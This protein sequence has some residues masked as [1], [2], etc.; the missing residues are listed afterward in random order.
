VSGK[1]VIEYLLL[2]DRLI[3]GSAMGL[4]F[5][6]A[7]IYT[8]FGV[9]MPMSAVQMTA[10]SDPQG[11][12]G[13][14]EGQAMYS[15][16]TNG[17]MMPAMWSATYAGL[18]FLM[19][20]I[21]MIAMMLPSVTSTVL[22]YMSLIRR[23]DQAVNAPKLAFFFLIGYLAVWGLFSFLATLAQWFLE[24]RGVVSPMGMAF[25]SN[26]MGAT[27]LIIVGIY[28]FTPWKQSCLK[29]CRS[30]IK[31]L[32]EKHR[33]GQNGALLMGI[34]HGAFCLG[35]CW[36]LMVLLLVGG[37][38]NLYWIAGLMLFVLTEKLIRFGDKISR[39]T[40]MLMAGA[41]IYLL[42]SA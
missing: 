24:L 38:M 9:G 6:I 42:I 28:Q 18:V 41:G 34:E 33:T 7:V 37:I 13:T 32:S 20:W 14:S 29:H 35:C 39:L 1:P 21:M 27:V 25:T 17:L 3:T 36:C 40:G 31:F 5:L 22:L 19:W 4:I 8:I 11:M 15:M 16:Q 30:P 23:G 2:Q 12:V 10:M 26:I